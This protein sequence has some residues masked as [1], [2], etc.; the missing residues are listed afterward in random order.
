MRELGLEGSVIFYDTDNIQNFETQRR[1]IGDLYKLSDV[2]IYPSDWESFGMQL[3]EAAVAG[4][5]IA[6]SERI[7][8]RAQL[9]GDNV[10]VFDPDNPA[11]SAL[12]ILYYLS[13]DL[14]AEREMVYNRAAYNFNWEDILQSD[15]LPL[16]SSPHAGS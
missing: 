14:T 5:P 7:G 8:P 12:G 4:L 16:L 6:V 1:F 2:L 13:R 15:L 3:L 11:G 10:Y 9:L